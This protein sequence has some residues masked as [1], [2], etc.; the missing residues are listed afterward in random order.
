M[1]LITLDVLIIGHE[2]KAKWHRFRNLAQ[3]LVHVKTYIMRL[4]VI[5]LLILIFFSV[6]LM[7]QNSY[8]FTSEI[9]KAWSFLSLNLRNKSFQ[10]EERLVRMLEQSG[11]KFEHFQ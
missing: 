1:P 4:L 7:K 11:R 8:L 6:D 10:N 3:P 9:S 5:V 2:T